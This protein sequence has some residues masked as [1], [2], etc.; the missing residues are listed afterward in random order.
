MSLSVRDYLGDYLPYVWT[1]V[2]GIALCAGVCLLQNYRSTG[3][4]SCLLNKEEGLNTSLALLTSL[5]DHSIVQPIKFRNPDRKLTDEELASGDF[6]QGSSASDRKILKIGSNMV[7]KFGSGIDL[8]EAE[9]MCFIQNHT[10]IPVPAVFNAYE[11]DGYQYIL[12]ENVEGES[13]DKAWPRMTPDEK[14]IVILELKDFVCQ[15]RK[16]PHPSNH[17]GSVDGGPAID[18]RQLS[19]ISGGPFKSE[20][21]FNQWQLAQLSSHVPRSRCDIY[22]S[23]FK[24][25]HDIVFSHGDLA[26]HNILVKHGHITAIIDWECAG[27]YPEHWDYCKTLSFL[28]GTDEEYRCCRE[29][30]ERAYHEEYLVDSWFTKDVRHGL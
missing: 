28:S 5:T 18:S 20:A 23:M 9:N 12:M 7:A 22:E 21:Q 11:Q 3:Q 2:L 26:F 14:K 6:I 27:W 25:D 24:T 4:D 8:S 29:V 17:I 10:D 15:M 16:I 30:F 1:A 13:L 19:T